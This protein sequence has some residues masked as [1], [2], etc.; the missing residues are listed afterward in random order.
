[1]VVTLPPQDVRTYAANFGPPVYAG[2]GEPLNWDA[3]PPGHPS[4]EEW[5][6]APLCGRNFGNATTGSGASSAKTNQYCGTVWGE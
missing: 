1:M 5:L 6:Q 3:V 2:D 4:W